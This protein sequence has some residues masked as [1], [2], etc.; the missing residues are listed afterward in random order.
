MTYNIIQRAWE[1]HPEAGGRPNPVPTRAVGT[2]LLEIYALMIQLYSRDGDNGRLRDL[3]VR[4]QRV[5]GGIPHPRT[6]A[7]IKECGGKMHMREREFEEAAMAF[8]D[9]FRSYDEA[10]DAG[11]LRCLKYQVLAS[12][13]SESGISPFDSPEA[14][15]FRDHEEIVAMTDLVAASRDGD[16][17]KF[18]KILRRSGDRIMGDT[19]IRGYIDDLLRT[20]RSQVVLRA[21]GPYT[22]VSLSFLS[23]ELN[24]VEEDD[25]EGLLASLILD[26]RLEGRID[27]VEMVLYRGPPPVT[28]ADK[29][30]F[31][32]EELTAAIGKMTSQLITV[33]DSSIST[34]GGDK[35]GRIQRWGD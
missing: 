33:V 12:M 25:V 1:E 11:R 14:R 20:V 30:R 28:V 32:V 35:G 21:I 29:N 22:R 24:G 23:K 9:A 8:F 17:A 26:G 3:Y 34:G 27:Q 18:E 31:A 15:P 5:E 13:L 19:F 2:N 6:L 16:V 10:G 4:S 7:V